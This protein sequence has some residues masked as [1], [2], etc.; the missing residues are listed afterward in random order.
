MQ[1][2]QFI[3]GFQE[4]IVRR[5]V[6]G[7]QPFFQLPQE[8]LRLLVVALERGQPTLRYGKGTP[9]AALWV[10]PLLQQVRNDQILATIQSLQ[11]IAKTLSQALQEKV[12]TQIN[13]FK[14]H[15]NPM[16]YKEIIKAR[17]A[18]KSDE[19][20][21]QQKIKAN[22][23]LGSGAIESTCRQYQC[24]FKRTGQFWSL[25]GDEALMCLE[26]FWRNGR[27]EELYPHVKLTSPSLN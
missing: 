24:R 13:Y 21:A 20:T 17:K 4:R 10:K 27:W 1:S 18:V 2:E 7:P 9:E 19:A 23:P 22:E 8:L 3:K 25:P 5:F 16:S 12:Q 26:T 15:S 14:N 11:E 6:Y